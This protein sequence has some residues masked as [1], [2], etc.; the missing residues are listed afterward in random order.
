MAYAFSDVERALAE[1]HV[2]ADERRPAFVSRLQHLQKRRFPPGV[3]T[4]RGRAASYFAEHAFLLGVALQMIEMS[5]TPERAI[6]IIDSS[7]PALAGGAIL[8]IEGS[9][10]IFCEVPTQT[11]MDLVYGDRAS[12][13]VGLLTFDDNFADKKLYL[14]KEVDGPIRWSIF[15][16]SGLITGLSQLLEGDHR[17]DFPDFLT[18]LLKW[19]SGVGGVE[20]VWR[21]R[22]FG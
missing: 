20:K 18:G 6:R 19:A 3:N 17:A 13:H 4:G 15:S 14:M 5:I 8:A 12:E 9:E 7:L 10:R 11:L 1:I 16:L 2:I 22:D 21:G